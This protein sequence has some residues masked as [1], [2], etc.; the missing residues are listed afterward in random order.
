MAGTAVTE[1]LNPSREDHVGVNEQTMSGPSA[2]LGDDWIPGIIWW[3]TALGTT[4]RE[5]RHRQH[6][7]CVN[8]EL[9]LTGLRHLD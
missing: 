6:P 5:R 7:Y 9:Q 2:V 3:P 4:S 1:W 8:E